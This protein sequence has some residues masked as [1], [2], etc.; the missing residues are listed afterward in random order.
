[1]RWGAPYKGSKN[2]IAEWVIK[3]FPRR[4][5]FYD[6]FAGGCAVTHCAAAWHKF[7]NFIINDISDAPSLFVDAVNGKFKDEKRWISRAD[8]SALKDSEPYVRYCW[9]FGNNGDD[10][11]YSVEVEPW[12]K[13]LHYARVLGDFSLLREFGIDTDDASRRW[14]QK[15]ETE[16]KKKYI[17]WALRHFG[18]S[19]EE[20][21]E[22]ERLSKAGVF[23]NVIHGSVGLGQLAGRLPFLKGSAAAGG[24]RNEQLESLQRLQSLQSLQ[25]L[26]QQR[27]L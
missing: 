8:F 14:I 12:K 4:R 19:P 16:C 27:F 17:D 5:N 13:A 25:R 21:A 3:Q 7:D 23:E 11:M 15:N 22:W 26:R 9:S 6:L 10:Y 18:F 20:V 2:Q 1:M 24:A